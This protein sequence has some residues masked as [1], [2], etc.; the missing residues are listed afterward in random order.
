MKLVNVKIG[1]RVKVTQINTTNSLLLQRLLE[2][3][4]TEECNL[5]VVRKMPFNGPL[6]LATLDQ[7]FCIRYVDAKCISVKELESDGN[8]ANWKSEYWKNVS[9]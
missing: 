7:T 2:F 5:K 9:I 4:I 1:R 6:V 8:W 3:G